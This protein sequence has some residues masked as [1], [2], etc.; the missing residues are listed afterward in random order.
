[1]S[2]VQ[3]KTQPRQPW[4]AAI[5]AKPPPRTAR[6]PPKTQ[7]AAYVPVN[8]FNGEQLQTAL[9]AK[10]KQIEAQVGPGGVYRG[11]PAWTTKNKKRRGLDWCLS[12]ASRFR[13]TIA[14]LSRLSGPGACAG[15]GSFH[16]GYPFGVSVQGPE[17]LL[18]QNINLCPSELAPNLRA[19]HLYCGRCFRR[20]TDSETRATLSTVPSEHAPHSKHALLKHGRP[21]ACFRQNVLWLPHTGSVLRRSVPKSPARHCAFL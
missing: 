18:V 3:T 9:A 4:A 20:S 12:R 11:S 6:P 2:S 19:V 13:H 14:S 10:F 16:P 8:N 7:A 5:A 17:A 1:M 15:Q 21:I